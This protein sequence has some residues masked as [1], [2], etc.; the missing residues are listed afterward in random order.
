MLCPVTPSPVLD[1]SEPHVSV[2]S[3][4]REELS[5][6]EP[7]HDVF[8]TALTQGKFS[9]SAALENLPLLFSH[10][11][12][13][14][15]TDVISSIQS[16]RSLFGD[17]PSQTCVLSHDIDVGDSKPI[18]QHPYRVHP[19]KR[20]CLKSQVEYI[21]EHGIAVKSSSV[22]S[23]PCLLA[24]KVNGEDRFCTDFRKVN[25]VTSPDCFP[26]P[27]MED[28]VEHVGAARF[29]TKLDLLKGCL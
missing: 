9:N 14:Q 1:A 5:G 7:E 4:G 20:S 22:W 17:L 15:Q 26:L 6:A 27:R 12:F 28:C 16:Y 23:S 11:D 25:G 13:S 2:A 29:V 10:L 21:V 18:K 3:G 24:I 8:S 19:D